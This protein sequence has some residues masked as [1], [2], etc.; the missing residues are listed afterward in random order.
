MQGD[1]IRSSMFY[2]TCAALI[3]PLVFSVYFYPT[4]VA[5]QTFL[6]RGIVDVMLALW[7][8]GMARDRS[9]VPTFSLPA[10]GVAVFVCA[11]YAA[12]AFGTG[13]S[14]SFFSDYERHW[15]LLTISHFAIFFF[16]L[17]SVFRDGVTWRRLFAVSVGA[18]VLCA[19]YGLYQFF[20]T[21]DIGRIY[22]TIGN[23]AF[24][25]S[26]LVLNGLVAIFLCV[27]AA[28]RNEKFLWGAA[29]IF[30]VGIAMLSGTR[31]AFLAVLVAAVFVWAGFLWGS[32]ASRR[33]K[34]VT[35][36][37]GV[38]AAA[39]VGALFLFNNAPWITGNETLARLTH[40]SAAQVTG[41]TRF[42]AWRATWDGFKEHPVLGVGPEYFDTVFNKHFSSDFYALE[43]SE[44]E[45][46][47]AHN[48]FL[49][50]LATAGV[51]GAAAYAFLFLAFL[52]AL[53]HAVRQ[54]TASRFGMAGLLAVAVAYLVQGMFSFDSFTNFL[55]L[56]LVFAY[57]AILTQR[58]AG[59]REAGAPSGGAVIGA[60]C[61]AA[62][63]LVWYGSVQPAR[64]DR[65]LSDLNAVRDT[66]ME[67]DET[68]AVS[69]A[70]AAHS[71]ALAHDRQSASVA[72][73]LL[74]RITREAYLYFGRSAPDD[75]ETNLLPY[76]LRQAAEN[77]RAHP[78]DY[79][80]SY[81]LALAH[82][83]AYL[84]AG[85]NDAALAATVARAETLAPG[86]VELQ[87]ASA[88]R[89]LLQLR[90]D[91][92]IAHA[93]K[94]IVTTAWFPD[95]YHILFLAYNF[96]GDT[97]RAFAAAENG[98]AHGMHLADPRELLW[99]ADQYQRRGILDKAEA[100]RIQAG[101]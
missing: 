83:I 41:Q 11:E 30:I 84:V 66:Q 82:N 69:A 99:M 91:D 24:F 32:A 93:Q 51:V 48:V 56:F 5:L 54:G 57:A 65:A 8:I 67:L 89:S 101:Q 39:A 85:T 77:V 6:F 34:L 15:G 71:A 78:E 18:G 42:Y 4:H 45:F 97:D 38:L 80:A 90:F 94:G 3:T 96:K 60:V 46:D 95:F 44:T 20:F 59:E 19:A 70:M 12:A 27:T 50:Q 23:P 72:T 98:L 62:A 36:G 33:A 61:V 22:G 10:L 17:A 1:I 86:R 52:A 81:D 76:A 25:S 37:A 26:Y 79:F 74:E 87:F 58:P 43:R 14:R 29:A 49:E 53:V 13:F 73:P 9:F 28:S 2:L 40:I 64:A 92:A 21:P 35:A 75:F 100:F 31:A 88:Q 55:P 7:L 63:L 68:T 16:I 47:R